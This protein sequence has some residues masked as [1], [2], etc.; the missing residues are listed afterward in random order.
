MFLEISNL[1]D[2]SEAETTASIFDFILLSCS[3]KQFTVVPEPTPR[4]QPLSIY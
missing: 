3:I 2:D 4:T 1:L